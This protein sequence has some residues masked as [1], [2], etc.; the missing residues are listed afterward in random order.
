MGK[1]GGSLIE[2][3]SHRIEKRKRQQ[4]VLQEQWRLQAALKMKED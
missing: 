1:P 4:Q 3:E 2:D